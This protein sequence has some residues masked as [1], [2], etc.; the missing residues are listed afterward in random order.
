MDDILWRWSSASEAERASVKRE[1]MPEDD[2]DTLSFRVTS[3]PVVEPETGKISMEWCEVE[4][5]D[6]PASLLCTIVLTTATHQIT[7]EWHK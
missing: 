5:W 3:H 4:V 6:T 7:Y 2:I 1:L